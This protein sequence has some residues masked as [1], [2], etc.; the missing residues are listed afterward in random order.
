MAPLAGLIGAVGEFAKFFYLEKLALRIPDAKLASH[1]RYIRWG[2]VVALAALIVVGAIMAAVAFRA[3]VPGFA[4][5]WPPPAP[6]SMRATGATSMPVPSPVA[7][8]GRG[9]GGFMAGAC[10]VGVAGL[11]YLVF[12]IAALVLQWRLGRRFREQAELARRTW[13]GA[14]NRPGVGG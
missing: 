10:L 8:G 1:A 3:G 5:G 13:A 11:A 7:V 14:A 12:A 6:A 4:A 9:A 2:L